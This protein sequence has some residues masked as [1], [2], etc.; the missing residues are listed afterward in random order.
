MVKN[1]VTNAETVLKMPKGTW[2]IP[3]GSHDTAY[4]KGSQRKASISRSKHTKVKEQKKSPVSIF[5]H[6]QTC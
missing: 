1:N 6:E 2:F 4:A 5:W 3:I